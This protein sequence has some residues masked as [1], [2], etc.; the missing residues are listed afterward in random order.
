MMD[1]VDRWAGFWSAPDPAR[2]DDLAAPEI[3][4]R[5]PGLA[6]PLRGVEAWRD[7]VASIVDRFPD[8]RLTVTDH[9]A[10]GDLCFVSWRGN[11]T[12]NGKSLSWEGIDRMRLRDGLVVDSLVAFDTAALR[13]AA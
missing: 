2:V 4:L 1:F 6:E 8:I 3:E 7:R 10:A 11:A 13:A 9:A 5:Y 12:V